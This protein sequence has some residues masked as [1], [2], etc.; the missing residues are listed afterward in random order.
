MTN[1]TEDVER[2]L[3]LLGKGARFL[4]E[5][6]QED[7][8]GE[9]LLA[10]ARRGNDEE[11]EVLLGQGADINYADPRTNATALH[12][13]ASS[14]AKWAIKALIKAPELDYLVRDHKGRFPSALAFEIAHN[15]VIGRFLMKKEIQQSRLRGKDY[16]AMLLGEDRP[17]PDP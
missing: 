13:A 7:I 12:F 5:T 15:T 16:R 8:L 3:A 4:N 1:E 2:K 11:I 10:A 17:E 9:K 6:M 14:N